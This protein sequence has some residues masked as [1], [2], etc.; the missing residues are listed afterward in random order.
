MTTTSGFPRR[1]R[2][3]VV[4]A[5]RHTEGKAS[6]PEAVEP[7]VGRWTHD[8]RSRQ[9]AAPSFVDALAVRVPEPSVLRTRVRRVSAV[10][11]EDRWSR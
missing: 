4:L 5:A 11:A 2:E 10:R 8:G 3:A 6:T 1:H 9:R 7:A